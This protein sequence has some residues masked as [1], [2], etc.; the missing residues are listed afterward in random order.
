M[1]YYFLQNY[2]PATD[3]S[4]DIKRKNVIVVVI[5]DQQFHQIFLF[6]FRF[7]LIQ[8]FIINRYLITTKKHKKWKKKS[9]KNFNFTFFHFIISFDYLFWFLLNPF[10]FECIHYHYFSSY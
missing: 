8:I 4:N 9:K 5:G 3:N 6:F 2:K 10:N 1:Y 7:Y